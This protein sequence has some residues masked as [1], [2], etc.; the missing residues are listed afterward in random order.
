[1]LLNHIKIRP[2][3]SYVEKLGR[4]TQLTEMS[5]HPRLFYIFSEKSN[6]NITMAFMKFDEF[7]IY[8]KR[9]DQEKQDI[10]EKSKETFLKGL[11]TIII[12][13]ATD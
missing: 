13:T 5:I 2:K 8:M 10:F 3:E 12:N 1:M 4:K 6:Q 9:K 11:K 7:K